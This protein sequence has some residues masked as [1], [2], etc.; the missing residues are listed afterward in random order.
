MSHKTI[1]YALLWIKSNI[2]REGLEHITDYENEI[3]DALNETPENSTMY[4]YLLLLY[5]I[6]KWQTSHYKTIMK[7]F[8]GEEEIKDDTHYL[9]MNILSKMFYFTPRLHR[10]T[11][12]FRGSGIRTQSYKDYIDKI[13]SEGVMNTH[14]YFSATRSFFIAEKFLGK[15]LENESVMMILNLP[16]GFP[17]FI[18]EGQFE[19]EVLIPPC[20]K[21][22]VRKLLTTKFNE[23]GKVLHILYCTPI[24]THTWGYALPQT[25][26]DDKWLKT[27]LALDMGQ[28]AC[29]IGNRMYSAP[30]SSIFE[31]EKETFKLIKDE[32]L[33]MCIWTD[34]SIIDV[35][36]AIPP[37]TKNYIEETKTRMFRNGARIGT[38]PPKNFPFPLK[39]VEFDDMFAK[40]KP[41]SRLYQNIL[42]AM[43]FHLYD[44]NA[45]VLGI[46][47]DP[48]YYTYLRDKIKKLYPVLYK[49]LEKNR[50]LLLQNNIK[51]PISIHGGAYYQGRK[52][53]SRRRGKVSSGRRKVTSRRRKVTSRRRKVTSRRRM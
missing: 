14:E 4:W 7:Y 5:P 47:R 24:M 22:S 19:Q 45:S 30:N 39:H 26:A 37:P 29:L 51:R 36:K 44:E 41:K 20:I 23:E 16:K 2:Q 17:A 12:V 32:P 46:R 15:K 50:E 11:L 6:I 42:E 43:S 53:T 52:V 13:L 25:A 40:G 10:G 38:R 9:E 8:R 18:F 34:N 1:T 31:S 28:M 33:G 21:W 48:E 3:N 27:T 49:T 35:K